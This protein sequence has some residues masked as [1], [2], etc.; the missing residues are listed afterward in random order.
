MSSVSQ[1]GRR[2]VALV[3]AGV[4]GR[5]HGQVI[6]QLAD[7]LEL[8]AVIDP[9][10]ERGQHIVDAHGGRPY[11]GLAEALAVEDIDI[12]VVCTPTGTHGQVAI[13]ALQA[14]KDVIIEKPAEITVERTDEIIAAQQASGR[15]VTVIS[16]HRFDAATEVTV[17]AIA[18]GELGR[19]TSGIASHRLVAGAELL[20]LR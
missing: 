13:E 1:S 12:V 18:A 2:R 14:G 17:D 10:A 7:R 20:R 5:H 15:L 4:I 8:V 3:G 19:L 9:H 6:T 16:Q 11:G